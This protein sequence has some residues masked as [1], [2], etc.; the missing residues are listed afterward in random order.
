M[1][2]LNLIDKYVYDVSEFFN[3]YDSS[4]FIMISNSVLNKKIA[5]FLVFIKNT[6]STTLLEAAI[7]NLNNIEV[8]STA[9]TEFMTKI[10]GSSKVDRSGLMMKDINNTGKINVKPQY[11]K[12]AVTDLK[13]NIND[14]LSGK[15]NA[16][17][18]IVNLKTMI[19]STYKDKLKQRSV[20]IYNIPYID[21]PKEFISNT[22]YIS[23][24][25]TLQ[26]INSTVIPYVKN[27]QKIKTGII[28]ETN[29]IIKEINNDIHEIS[30]T[31][32]AL[33]S[34]NIPDDKKSIILNYCYNTI[35]S[36]LEVIKFVTYC[37]MRKIHIIEENIAGKRHI[38]SSHYYLLMK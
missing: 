19:S 8:D 26:Y 25:I 21:N 23:T 33:N 31:M 9:M 6:E 14:L 29:L 7:K 28:T 20:E 34:V 5:D 3:E 32:S 11:L 15:I 17:S 16:D 35:R 4:S 36:I 27:F 1:S 2:S 18:A 22:S 30:L 38:I 12:E 13:F 10:L 37:Q 24:P